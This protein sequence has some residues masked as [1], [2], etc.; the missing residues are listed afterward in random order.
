MTL[1]QSPTVNNDK[2]LRL[3]VALDELRSSLPAQVLS[4]L[5]QIN[6]SFAET[7]TT[8]KQLE[9]DK[10]ITSRKN[11]EAKKAG[12]SVDLLKH[13]I[14]QLSSRI[15]ECKTQ[16]SEFTREAERPDGRR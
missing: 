2:R 6:H 13:Q 12:Q 7:K 3:P 15:T 9:T 14:Q 5:E 11:G 8:L 1:P 4:R 16:Q 10:G